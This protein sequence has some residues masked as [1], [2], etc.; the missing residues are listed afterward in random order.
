MLF[1]L[2]CL[3][4]AEITDP[5]P[6]ILW[7]LFGGPGPVLEHSYPPAEHFQLFALYWLSRQDFQVISRRR[8]RP[9]CPLPVVILRD[10]YASV[11]H[12]SVEPFH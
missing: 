3:H 10:I 5:C 9:F 12:G 1:S 4:F 2:S 8:R 6:A 7:P 11:G